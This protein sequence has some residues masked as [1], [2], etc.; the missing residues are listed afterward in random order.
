MKKI[1]K[2]IAFGTAMCLMLCSCNNSDTDN[3]TSN[4]YTKEDNQ[5][6]QVSDNEKQNNADEVINLTMQ[7]IEYS[8]NQDTDFS[9]TESVISDPAAFGEEY[10][11]WLSEQVWLFFG[12]PAI[13]QWVTNPNDRFIDEEKDLIYSSCVGIRLN[14]E[15][16]VHN[17]NSTPVSYSSGKRYIIEKLNLTESCFDKLCEIAP[18]SYCEKDG[19]L[20]VAESFGGQ[21]GW[22][23]SIIVDYEVKDNVINYNCIRLSEPMSGN[24]DAEFTF[25]LKFVENEWLL[26]DCSY[27]EGFG[28][29]FAEESIIT[30]PEEYKTPTNCDLIDKSLDCESILLDR[31][32]TLAEIRLK[33]YYPGQETCAYN[34]GEIEFIEELGSVREI[35]SDEFKTYSEFKA[36][37]S[38][39]IYEKYIDFINLYGSG[40]REYN[41]KI[42]FVDFVSGG[43]RGSIETWYLG[44]D[45][46]DDKI[47]GHFAELH[48]DPGS[49]EPLEAEYLNDESSYDFYDIIIQNIDGK[50]VLTNCISSDNYPYHIEHGWLYNSGEADRTLI[51]NE[52]VKPATDF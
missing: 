36:L 2:F 50:Y 44:Y 25:S 15:E 43:P 20:Y 14:N 16:P 35:S 45:L 51:T 32:G 46:E 9:F 8:E 42:Y 47:I 19:K 27:V 22:R 52:K 49:D 28:N 18:S 5:T 31:A 11:K 10:G 12:Y 7:E 29:H 26:D 6:T 13:N 4:D 37:F 48:A 30:T 17:E 40:I 24:E 23:G 21:A 38:D 3:L 33:Y 1:F 41:G 39:K 34:V